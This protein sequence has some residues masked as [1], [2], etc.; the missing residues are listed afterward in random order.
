MEHVFDFLH[1]LSPFATL[2]YAATL[3]TTDA[4]VVFLASKAVFLATTLVFLTPPLRR[5]A[6]N[7][8]AGPDTSP[9]RLFER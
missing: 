2:D 5:A 7:V 3:S 4:V 9:E 6:R 8:L 1:K